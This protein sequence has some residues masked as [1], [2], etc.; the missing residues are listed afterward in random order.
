MTLCSEKRESI[1]FQLV[2]GDSQQIFPFA[3]TNGDKVRIGRNPKCEVT[4]MRSRM[5]RKISW[6]H[7]EILVTT[8]AAG[9]LEL[10]VRD[11]SSNGTALWGADGMR[12]VAK[13]GEYS[14]LHDGDS[15]VLPAKAQADLRESFLVR[16]P[17][18]AQLE[19]DVLDQACSSMDA[20][21]LLPP[22]ID[23]SANLSTDLWG[24]VGDDDYDSASSIDHEEGACDY[25]RPPPSGLES[26]RDRFLTALSGPVGDGPICKEAGILADRMSARLTPSARSRIKTEHFSHGGCVRPWLGGA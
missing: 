7:C 26:L 12:A 10:A 24:N 20:S 14:V 15:I 8:S 18:P 23:S 11:V 1:V 22:S 25:Q 16:I 9:S 6:I 4:L 2:C 21:T 19:K 17:D 13:S 3:L 5:A